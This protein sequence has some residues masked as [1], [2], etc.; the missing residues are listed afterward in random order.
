MLIASAKFWRV[1]KASHHLVFM[2][3]YQTISHMFYSIVP[4]TQWMKE[5]RMWGSSEITSYC[6]CVWCES[7]SLLRLKTEGVRAVSH[8]YCIG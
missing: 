7:S 1:R 3:N 6:F 4:S 2:G 8:V 5:M